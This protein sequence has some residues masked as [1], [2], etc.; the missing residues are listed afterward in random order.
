MIIKDKDAHAWSEI[1]IEEEKSWVRFDPTVFVAPLRIEL[2]GDVYFQFSDEE[3]L[4]G[5]A[6]D[7]Y[8]AAYEQSWAYQLIGRT[9][10]VIDML[11]TRWNYFLL[12]YD[13]QG[14][15]SFFKDLGLGEIDIKYLAL[16]SL[17]IVLLFVAW[18][19]WT[20]RDKKSRSDIEKSYDKLLELLKKHGID[21]KV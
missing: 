8:L 17:I 11:S 21:K 13:R 7:D 3:I 18:L 12:S 10:L 20:G 1:W 16:L 6:G 4:Q 9:R 15:I 14:Q 5:R 19:R 2:G